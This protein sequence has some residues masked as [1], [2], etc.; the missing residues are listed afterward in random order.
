MLT[1]PMC[2]KGLD[3][4]E[5]ECPTCKADLTLLKEYVE[6]LNASVASAE[7]QLRQGKLGESVW[8]YLEVLEVDPQNA[9]ARRQIG[10]V[11][12]AVRHFD[13]TASKEWMARL[14][15]HDRFR[16][17]V[18]AQGQ[19]FFFRISTWISI[20]LILLA[21]AL[22][23]ILC[24]R[25]GDQVPFKV[26]S[27]GARDSQISPKLSSCSTHK[28]KPRTNSS[29]AR[30]VPTNRERWWGGVKIAENGCRPFSSSI[31]T[32]RSA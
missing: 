2:K 7:D 6:N 22:G 17:W 21:F 4:L 16:R 20:V 11:V 8:K 24:E 28:R 14:S 19:H 29:T 31:A 23:W 27:S 5:K 9:I 32:I 13:R 10:Q 18:R 12:T 15:K 1:C 30:N 26:W 25:F 3:K